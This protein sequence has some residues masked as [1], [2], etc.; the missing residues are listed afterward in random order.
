MVSEDEVIIADG[1]TEDDGM[2]DAGDASE[3]INGADDGGADG[4]DDDGV[5]VFWSNV[6]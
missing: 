6:R 5:A 1:F 2:S 4:V 3:S